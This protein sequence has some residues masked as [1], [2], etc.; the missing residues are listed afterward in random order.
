MDNNHR[1]L[2]ANEILK[3]IPHRYPFL[4]VDRV[5]IIDDLKSARGIKCVSANELFFHGHFP[6]RPIMP[7][8]LILES[9]AQ[10]SATLMV[11]SPEYS[12]R[13][14]YFAGINKARFRKQVIPGDVLEIYINVERIRGKIAKVSGLAS[15]GDNKVCDA[16][17]IFAVD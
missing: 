10:T 17:L 2:N 4:M 1:I 7:G 6:E 14:A 13:F 12:G 16:E 8:V 11:C 9:M 15:V 3:I 5:E